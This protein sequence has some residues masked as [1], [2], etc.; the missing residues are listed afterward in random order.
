MDRVRSQI[1]LLEDAHRRALKYICEIADRRV[2]PDEG[3]LQG[4][5]AFDEALPQ[6]STGGLETLRLLDERGSPATVATAGG[7]YFGFVVGGSIPVATAADWLVTAWDQTGTLPVSSPAVAKIEAVAG[8]W[9]REVLGLPEEAVTSFVTGASMANLLGLAAARTHLLHRAGYDL[10]RLGMFGAPPIRVVAGA[11]VHS[12]LLKVLGVLGFGRDRVELVEADAQGRLRADRLPPL[13]ERT[14]V[15][16][17]AGNVNSGAFDPFADVIAAARRARSWVHVDG[18]FG[19]WAAATPKYAQLTE[20]VEDADSWAV[21]AHKWLNVPYDSAML[22]CRHGD[23]LQAAM[24]LT[25]A[26]APS[27][28]EMPAKDLTLEFSRRARGVPVWAALRTLGRSGV[29]D[30]VEQCS[31]NARLLASGLERIG[32]EIH[33]EVVLNQVVASIGDAEFTAAVRSKVERDGGCW[34][35]P[36]QWKGR[37]AVRFSVSSWATTAEDIEAA[38]NAIASAVESLSAQRPGITRT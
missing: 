24:R 29:A 28:A 31:S 14:I 16:L 37:D 22:I 23:A 19:L 2:F 9:V 4:L 26:Y 20:G 18:A 13:D 5:A 11:E 36:T 33:N 38:V 21:D 32:F 12:T 30:L 6:D 35:G 3:A 25:A 17:Q 8:R 7:R 34:F 27:T 1:P 15:L 10:E